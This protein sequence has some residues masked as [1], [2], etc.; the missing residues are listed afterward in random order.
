MQSL[1]LVQHVPRPPSSFLEVI[2]QNLLRGSQTEEFQK[3]NV[4]RKERET[5]TVDITVNK[6]M[7]D[8]GYREKSE[9]V[10]CF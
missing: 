2:L 6:S 9:W 5:V 1:R 10:T 7:K 8:S 3:D 4:D